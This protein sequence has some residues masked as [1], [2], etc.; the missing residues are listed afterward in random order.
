ME[1]RRQLIIVLLLI[2]LL[3][4]IGAVGYKYF[5]DQGITW[6]DA[7]YHTILTVASIGYTDTGFGTTQIQKVYGIVF[8]AIC[9]V[10]LSLVA[11]AFV[12]YF[13]QSKL[14]RTIWEVIMNF[15][16]EF[17]HNHHVIFGVNHVAPYIIQEFYDTKTPFCVV[18]MNENDVEELSS[19]YKN[20]IIFY[21]PHK[22]FTDEMLEKVKIK[23]A[24][25]A[26]IDLGNDETNHITADLIREKN[27]KIKILSVGEEMSYAP[28]MQKRINHVVN[29]HF[30]CA[31]RLT[32]LAKRPSVVTHLDRMLYK[33]DG[34]Y[35]VEEVKISSNSCLIGKTLGE[36]DFPKTLKLIVTEIMRATDGGY[37]SNFLPLPEDV[38]T[39]KMIL[40]VQGKVEDVEILRNLAD[41]YIKLEDLK[42]QV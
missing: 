18:T 37:D 13:V 2:L 17:K 31:M 23:D 11:A 19:K 1:V 9:I 6:I 41:G 40:I 21:N 36:I 3:S 20:L 22:Y 8:M 27:P 38:I 26:T 5:G 12:A 33:K 10:A 34:V 28:V 29:P 7:F 25:T 24:E 15:K 42:K 30:M 14:H 32:S 16:M 4:I 39:D 35:R